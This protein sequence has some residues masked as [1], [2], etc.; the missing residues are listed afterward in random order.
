[1]VPT[2]VAGLLFGLSVLFAGGVATADEI[3]THKVVPP[4]GVA[5]GAAPAGL[6]SG[7]QAAT[8]YG[9]PEKPTMFVMR[10][11]LPKGYRIAPH[12][13]RQSEVITVISGAL[14]LGLGPAADRSTIEPLVAG[15]LS[16][17]PHGV[18]HYLFVNED[19][20]IQINADGPWDI[21]YV[22]PK[23]D[24]RLT[25]PPEAPG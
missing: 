11:K 5:W 21:E 17:M 9:D 12:M 14:S 4:Q 2:T 15:S 6:P 25:S 24:P 13:H 10:L 23:D 1:M 8:L 22:N 19:S 3:E 16:S 20:I 7:A 18:V